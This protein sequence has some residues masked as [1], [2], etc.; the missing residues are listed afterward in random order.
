MGDFRTGVRLPSGPPKAENQ[1][2]TVDL[3]ESLCSMPEHR[4]SFRK[5]LRKRSQNEAFFAFKG[6]GSVGRINEYLVFGWDL[7]GVTRK[8]HRTFDAVG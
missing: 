3:C 2:Y 1:I 5:S 6:F 4:T 8:N 7:I